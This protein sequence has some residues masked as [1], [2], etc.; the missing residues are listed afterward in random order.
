MYNPKEEMNLALS[1]L[2]QHL[3]IYVHLILYQI[4]VYNTKEILT[5]GTLRG[6]SIWLK[7]KSLPFIVIG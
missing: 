4:I 5:R 1:L 6:I 3:Q 7:I 2:Q